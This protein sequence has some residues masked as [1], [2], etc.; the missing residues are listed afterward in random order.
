M[1]PWPLSPFLTLLAPLHGMRG[2]SRSLGLQQ[3]CSNVK[4]GRACQPASLGI[5]RLG[6]YV[7]QTKAGFAETRPNRM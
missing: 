3:I 1:D 7:I 6:Q 2:A 5:I 4:I